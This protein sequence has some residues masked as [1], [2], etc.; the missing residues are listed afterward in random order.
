MPRAQKNPTPKR[1]VTKTTARQSKRLPDS[2]KPARCDCAAYRW[3]HRPGGGLCRWPDPPTE[4]CPTPAGTN[5]RGLARHRAGRSW[6]Y[7]LLGLNPMIDAEAFARLYPMVRDHGARTREQAEAF[8]A[9]FQA[10]DP[11][12]L[13]MGGTS[14]HAERQPRDERGRF[15][16][17]TGD[18][19]W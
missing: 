17:D 8:L 9:Y 14:W 18:E 12:R 16:R 1:S 4:T 13:K 11:W 19:V 10:H 3:P 6:A 5:R 2:P 7:R 15:I